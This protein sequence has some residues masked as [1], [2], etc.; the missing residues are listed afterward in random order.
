MVLSN[1]VEENEHNLSLFSNPR[2]ENLSF[3]LDSINE[4]FGR[5]ALSFA[6]MKAVGKAAP[7]RI[8]FGNIPKGKEAE[9]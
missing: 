8:A 6:S 2:R 3:A 4:K 9:D 5:G 7:T 1:L